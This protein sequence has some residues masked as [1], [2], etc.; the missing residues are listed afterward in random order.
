MT[1]AMLAGGLFLA[2][3][4]MAGG[5]HAQY[6]GQGYDEG[7]GD[8]VVRCE[9]SDG[10]TNQCAADTRD[11]IRLVRQIS[12]TPCVEGQTWGY[13]RNS[14][15]VSQ[16]CR[17]EFITNAGYGGDY[18]GNYGNGG[19]Y[20][21]VLRCESVNG[22]Y[23]QCP[24]NVRG[25]VRIARQLSGTACIEGQSWGANRDGV[26]VDRGCRAEFQVGYRGNNGWGW[27]RDDRYG[28]GYGNDYGNGQQQVVRCE[29]TSGRTNRCGA[30]VYRG[31]QLVRQISGS[32]CIEGQSW[33]WDRGGIWV[34]QGCRGEFAVF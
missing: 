9:S 12:K 27:G 34:S 11:G 16:G 14:I 4:A 19:G 31:A 30:P 1:R 24:A 20:G 10:R 17:G 25:G 13:G 21:N 6:Y 33:G 8:Q 26:W 32:A 28:G 23:R 2:T 18:G 5:A 22:R 29:S 15:W 7:A 3:A